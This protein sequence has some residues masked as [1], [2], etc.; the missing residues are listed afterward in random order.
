M[1][2]YGDNFS[3][4]HMA[5][6]VETT[7]TP[8]GENLHTSVACVPS[9]P[10]STLDPG[11]S[12]TSTGSSCQGQDC[13]QRDNLNIDQGSQLDYPMSQGASWDGNIDQSSLYGENE[14]ED[15]LYRFRKYQCLFLISSF[16]F[17]NKSMI[18][19]RV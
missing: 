9:Q 6:T 18:S 11:Y 13:S 7:A 10:D 12:S 2:P 3:S 17:W 15:L 1:T 19:L 5:K 14:L 4:Y 16:E 8:R